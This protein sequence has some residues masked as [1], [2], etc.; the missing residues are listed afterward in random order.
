QERELVELLFIRERLAELNI[1]WQNEPNSE[2]TVEKN[3]ATFLTLKKEMDRLSEFAWRYGML[4]RQKAE[5]KQ[6][7]TGH[8]RFVVLRI[9]DAYSVV[10]R[11]ISEVTSLYTP[12]KKAIKKDQL[13]SRGDSLNA[14]KNALWLSAHLTIFDGFLKARSEEHTS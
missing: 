14:R 6:V 7:I 3:I 10:A 1:D 13:L 4:L 2:A 12:D 8:N 9:T 11:K 5:N